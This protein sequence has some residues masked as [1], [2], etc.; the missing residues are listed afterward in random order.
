VLAGKF[1]IAPALNLA[2]CWKH[3]LSIESQSAGNLL[4]LEI[5]EARP[6]KPFLLKDLLWHTL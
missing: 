4:N 1:Y 3:F 6:N 5:L 2:I